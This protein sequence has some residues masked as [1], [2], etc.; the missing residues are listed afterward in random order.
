LKSFFDDILPKVLAIVSRPMQIVEMA[1]IL[2]DFQ[3][4]SMD[5]N[6]WLQERHLGCN[7]LIG[8]KIT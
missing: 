3:K 2:I 7:S 4:T 8:P 6:K 5:L 1:L